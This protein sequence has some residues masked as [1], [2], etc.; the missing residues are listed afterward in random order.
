[1]KKIFILLGLLTFFLTACQDN[2]MNFT[3]IYPRIHVTK[4]EITKGNGENTIITNQTH[5]DEWINHMQSIIFTSE[6]SQ[7]KKVGYLYS[8]KMY[9]KDEEV[10][11]FTTSEINGYYYKENTELV[12][13]IEDLTNKK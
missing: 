1:M 7:E 4:I 12:S 3:D 8:I 13:A 11:H 6:E 10:G 2:T 9:N 5:I